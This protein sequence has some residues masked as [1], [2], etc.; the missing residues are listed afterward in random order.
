V[1]VAVVLVH[2]TQIAHLMQLLALPI[3][4]VAV[5]VVL[6]LEQGHQ[7]ALVLSS[8]LSQQTNIREQP[9]V[10]QRLRQAGQIQF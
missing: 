6:T 9:R 1:L 8:C 7:A 4:A 10:L 5:A 3:W 2:L